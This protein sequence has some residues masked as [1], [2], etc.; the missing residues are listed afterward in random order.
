MISIKTRIFKNLS[1]LLSVGLIV[2]V[3][4]LFHR[5][6]MSRSLNVEGLS[7]YAKMMP[8]AT[9][10]GVLASFSLGSSITQFVAKNLVKKPYSNR[11]LMAKGFKIATIKN[12]R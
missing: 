3:L 10:F 8:I 2:K 4:G 11:D 6:L 12:S 9:F 5:I 7:L 1:I